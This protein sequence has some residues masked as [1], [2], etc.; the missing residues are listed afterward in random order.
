MTM[1]KTGTEPLMVVMSPDTLR[2]IQAAEGVDNLLE[3]MEGFDFCLMGVP[4]NTDKFLS[5]SSATTYT[6]GSDVY[7]VTPGN[8]LVV[9]QFKIDA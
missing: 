1:E 7:V 6:V 2:A 9:T 3:D 4:G 5:T 8:P